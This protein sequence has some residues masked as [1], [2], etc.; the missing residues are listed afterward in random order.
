MNAESILLLIQSGDD[1]IDE[2]QATIYRD[3]SG[4][5]SQVAI[6]GRLTSPLELWDEL[7]GRGLPIPEDAAC[8]CASSAS[9]H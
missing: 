5:V 8:S 6:N 4:E 1:I 2:L 7:F 9:T 3:A